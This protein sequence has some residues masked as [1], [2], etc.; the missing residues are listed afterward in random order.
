MNI[1][2]LKEQLKDN[3]TTAW[4]KIQENPTFNNIKEKYEILPASTQK[5]MIYLS[6]VIAALFIALIPYSFIASSSDNVEK[7]EDSRDLTRQL[8]KSSSLASNIS[9]PREVSSEQLKG[10]INRALGVVQLTD[11]QIESIE[12]SKPSQDSRFIPKDVKQVAISISLK[13]LN[14]NQVIDAAHSL[15]NMGNN[16]V[17]L[18]MNLIAT[19][20]DPHYYNTNL[21]V[22]AF[23][24]EQELKEESTKG[25]KRNS[26]RKKRK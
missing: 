19:K 5:I 1:Q 3:L 2:D 26:R 14:I 7:F 12:E 23:S 6:G 11:E 17:L 16:I 15:N 21:E 13:K 9:L 8:L 22:R 20:E 4:E 10:K 25:T 18:N 24:F